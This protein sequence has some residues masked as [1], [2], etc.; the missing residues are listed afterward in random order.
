MLETPFWNCE[1]GITM[2]RMGLQ[3]QQRPYLY[4]DA[5]EYFVE[6]FL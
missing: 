1:V 5:F 6:P 3:D 2:N 4:K